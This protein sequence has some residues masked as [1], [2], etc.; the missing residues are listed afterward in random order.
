MITF[1]STPL[2]E[3]LVGEPGLEGCEAYDHSTVLAGGE[4][5][6]CTLTPAMVLQMRIGEDITLAQVLCLVHY[7]AFVLNLGAGIVNYDIDSFGELF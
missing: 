5:R 4:T 3:D 6:G 1:L 2:S 7:N